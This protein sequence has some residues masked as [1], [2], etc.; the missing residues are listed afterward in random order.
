MKISAIE[1]KFLSEATK[2]KRKIAVGIWRPSE[3]I[4]DGLLM[5]SAFADLT[6]VG[7]DLPGFNCINTK[8]DDEGSAVIIDLLKNKKVDGIVRAQLKD[9]FTFKL[10]VKEC[11]GNPHAHFLPVIMAKDDHC[12]MLSNPSNYNSLNAEDQFNEAE[13][14]ARYLKDEL[15][16]EPTIGVMSTRRPT[17]RVGEYPLLEQIANN[18]EYTAAELRKLGYDVKEY[19]IEAEKAVWEKR[20][21]LVTAGGFIGNPWCKSLAYLGGWH[22][23]QAP[24]LDQGDYYDDSPRNN[25]EW[26]WPIVSTVAWINRAKLK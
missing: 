14:A 11:V 19:Y 12:F 13:R 1:R 4:I 3:E 17:G 25:I 23:V 21:L 9:T 7:C 26:F 22:F 5:A 6:I 16:I 20:N 2:Q 8:T 15:K 24:Y 18:S 10:F